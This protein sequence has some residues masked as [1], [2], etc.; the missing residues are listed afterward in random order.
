MSGIAL[1]QAL[2]ALERIAPPALAESWDRSGLQVGDPRTLVDR[3]LIA[4]E[5]VAVL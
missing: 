5:E 4:L 2:Q 3:A 1:R